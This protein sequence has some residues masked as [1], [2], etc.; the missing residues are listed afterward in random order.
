MRHSNTVET[1]YPVRLMLHSICISNHNQPKLSTHLWLPSFLPEN[2]LRIKRY[3]FNPSQQQR[4]KGSSNVK[5]G[6]KTRKLRAS[7]VHCLAPHTYSERA[8]N[9]TR[10]QD[11]N[12]QQ[13]SGLVRHYTERHHCWV[14][15]ISFIISNEIV[16]IYVCA[17]GWDDCQFRFDLIIS[18][19]SELA[20]MY[21]TRHHSL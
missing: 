19:M 2:P 18:I 6:G 8:I 21:S 4:Q 13:S 20:M 7:S 15:C 1:Q 10:Y 14:G 5:H 9:K 12:N 16:C 11:M 3:A 17:Q